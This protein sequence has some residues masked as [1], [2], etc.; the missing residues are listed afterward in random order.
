[1]KAALLYQVNEDKLVK[2]IDVG[3]PSQ[4]DEMLVRTVAWSVLVA[5]AR[6]PVGKLLWLSEPDRQPRRYG[7]SQ[8]RGAYARS[9]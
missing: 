5:R 8:P 2:D 6:T 3:L 7:P 4:A 9:A 1:M